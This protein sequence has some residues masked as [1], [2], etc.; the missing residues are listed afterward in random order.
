M[1][2]V[3]AAHDPELDRPIA[4][5]LLRLRGPAPAEGHERLQREAKVMARLSHPAVVPVFDVGSHQDRLFVAME[6]VDGQTLSSWLKQTRP[7]WR[8]AL[9]ALVRAG[10]GLAA[11]HAAGIVHR[12]FKPDNVL[13]GADGRIRVTDFGLARLGDGAPVAEPSAGD[14]ASPAEGGGLTRGDAVMGTPG[15]MAPEQHLGRPAD[16]RA[17]QFSFCVALYEAVY[18]ERPFRWEP[19]DDV[20]SLVALA[21]E[22]TAGRVQPP[23]RGSRVPAWLRRVLVRGLAV[24]PAARWPTMDALLDAL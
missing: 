17:D 13:V 18:G 20:R 22:V 2:V 24:D 10:R 5:K 4:I 19:A 12:D 16:A 21:G 9:A 1:G 15:Y 11:A 3:Y 23:P 8:D 7:D 14:A 6:L